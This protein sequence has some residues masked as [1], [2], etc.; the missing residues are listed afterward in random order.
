M[1]ELKVGPED[2]KMVILKLIQLIIEE[3]I[4][5]CVLLIKWLIE[6]V[7]EEVLSPKGLQDGFV[8]FMEEAYDECKIDLPNLP[9]VWKDCVLATIRDSDVEE[10][11]FS[12]DVMKKL[13]V[14]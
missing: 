12:P 5:D 2:E 9:C 4:K 7:R 8:A 13:T 6:C 1:G 10:A 11:I 14:D 3:K